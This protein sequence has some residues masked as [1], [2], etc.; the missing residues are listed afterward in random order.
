MNLRSRPTPVDP[1]GRSALCTQGHDHRCISGLNLASQV[2]VLG[3]FPWTQILDL[4]QFQVRSKA[5][6]R[7]MLATLDLRTRLTW[8]LV[9]RTISVELITRTA[10]VEPSCRPDPTDWDTRLVPV[11]YMPGQDTFWYRHQATL[12]KNSS[13]CPSA[14]PVD[15][16]RNIW[17]EYQH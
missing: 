12:P 16:H 1:S 15:S 10:S 14:P 2:S 7:A 11:G 5:C 6:P 8:F 9:K 17:M 3:W 4:S 13:S